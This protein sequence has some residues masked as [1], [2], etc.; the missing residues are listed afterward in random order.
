MLKKNGE[1]YI[2]GVLYDGSKDIDFK[3][4]EITNRSIVDSLG[5]G[6]CVKIIKGKVTTWKDKLQVVIEDATEMNPLEMEASDII[7]SSSMSESELDEILE[8]WIG[9][10]PSFAALI[11]DVYSDPQFKIMAG[12]K[13]MHHAYK[14]GLMEH[15]V[16]TAGVAYSCAELFKRFYSSTINTEL[17]IAGALLHDIG[18]L[19]EFN[20]SRYGL[21]EDY[22]I[23]GGMLGHAAIGMIMLLPKIKKHVKDPELTNQLLHILA[24]HHG[25]SEQGAI[26]AP[27]T[28]EAFIVSQADMADAYVLARIAKDFYN[29]EKN[30]TNSQQEVIKKIHKS[31]EEG[32]IG[33]LLR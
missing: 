26:K 3:V 17:V 2:S 22:S 14:R 18:K 31:I 25:S 20:S 29:D 11:K 1:E 13:S 4:W 24:S 19:R 5:S 6:N 33:V 16:M 15:S 32:T 7:P 27:A 12:G 28:I 21:V 23:A 8:K 30:L 10:T 9:M